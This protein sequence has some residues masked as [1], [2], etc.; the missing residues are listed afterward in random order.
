M[1]RESPR[2]PRIADPTPRIPRIA[3]PTHIRNAYVC[4]RNS[5]RMQMRHLQEVGSHTTLAGVKTE[6]LS[7]IHFCIFDGSAE[8][9]RQQQ[10]L[11]G[12]LRKPRGR[13]KLNGISDRDKDERRTGDIAPIRRPARARSR[14]ACHDTLQTR[15][16]NS[17]KRL[18]ERGKTVFSADFYKDHPDVELGD[19]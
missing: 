12:N 16:T 10:C 8:Q 19:R 7:K 9:F 14:Q 2:I 18:I 5:Q 6:H 3:D 4:I 17:Q 15:L 11:V 1:L 13:F